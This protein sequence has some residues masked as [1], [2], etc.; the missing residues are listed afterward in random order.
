MSLPLETV[1]VK[2][3]EESS[4]FRG[5]TQGIGPESPTA[6]I[7]KV[8]KALKIK[9]FRSSKTKRIEKLH[10]AVERVL[11][12]NDC[13]KYTI[14]L[15]R[16]EGDSITISS[17]KI[18]CKDGIALGLGANKGFNEKVFYNLIFAIT[19]APEEIVKWNDSKDSIS[20]TFTD[21]RSMVT[22]RMTE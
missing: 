8:L 22:V 16:V 10:D 3:L 2:I 19:H 21:K 13:F 4:P 18:E 20:F 14:S 11:A 15:S 9:G 6:G 12:R 1:T 5:K 17:K 7:D